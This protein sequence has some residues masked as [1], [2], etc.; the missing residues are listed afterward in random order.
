M[1][2]KPMTF[3]DAGLGRNAPG[4]SKD[5]KRWSKLHN[6]KLHSLYSNKQ[7]KQTTNKTD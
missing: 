3:H 7:I 5:M 4:N 6:E 2:A 1:G